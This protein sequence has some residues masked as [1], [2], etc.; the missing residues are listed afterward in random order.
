[1]GKR[2]YSFAFGVCNKN[3]SRIDFGI[4]EDRTQ[5]NLYLFP[6]NRIQSSERF[7]H[8]QYLG[9]HDKITGNCNSLKL[10]AGEYRIFGPFIF[11]AIETNDLY[12]IHSLFIG[13]IFGYPFQYQR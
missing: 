13:F 7:V 4:F 10:T 6:G 5:K 12:H 8:Q 1:M 9:I 3:D 2:K 11:M